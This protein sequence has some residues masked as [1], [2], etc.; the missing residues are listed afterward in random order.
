MRNKRVF[1]SQFIFTFLICHKFNS[2]LYVK[3]FPRSSFVSSQ[4]QRM[5]IRRAEGREARSNLHV[6]DKLNLWGHF[7]HSHL[8][9]KWQNETLKQIRTH[10]RNDCLLAI[11][12]RSSPKMLR[13]FANVRSVQQLELGPLPMK[14]RY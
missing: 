8:I 5:G 7:R 13:I 14:W 1:C 9:P 12:S 2:K 6:Q 4:G 10:N 3:L 11:T